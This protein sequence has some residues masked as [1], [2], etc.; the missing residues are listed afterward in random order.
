MLRCAVLRFAS[1][2]V[3]LTLCSNETR[4]DSCTVEDRS[5]GLPRASKDP[6][7]QAGRSKN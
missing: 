5:F 1:L 2:A 3:L 7:V 4:L 6:F